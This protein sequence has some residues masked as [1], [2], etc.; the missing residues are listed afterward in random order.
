MAVVFGGWLSVGQSVGLVF[1][2]VVPLLSGELDVHSF[3]YSNTP[4][5]PLSRGDSGLCV[6]IFRTSPQQLVFA[7]VQYDNRG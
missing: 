1:L 5:S 6:Q 3:V 7:N 2:C 4:L